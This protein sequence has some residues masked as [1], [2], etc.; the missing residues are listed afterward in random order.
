MV[1]VRKVRSTSFWMTQW[2]SASLKSRKTDGHERSRA[3][4]SSS[5]F[6][7]SCIFSRVDKHFPGLVVVKHSLHILHQRSRNSEYARS[8]RMLARLPLCISFCYCSAAADFWSKCCRT[9]FACRLRSVKL[10]VYVGAC[11]LACVRARIRACL[12]LRSACQY[13]ICA[14][15]STTCCSLASCHC[16]RAW[17]RW[18]KSLLWRL[19]I[20][21]VT[22][23]V[24]DGNHPICWSVQVKNYCR[25]EALYTTRVLTKCNL[26]FNNKSPKSEAVE[27]LKNMLLGNRFHV[28]FT[29]L[30]S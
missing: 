27:S 17:A 29:H 25:C 12:C 22:I 18:I 19:D 7:P 4:L 24:E 11:V 16:S 2:R 1:G 13:G 8:P 20:V 30:H 3:F 14:I 28:F 23:E 21:Q 15:C 6:V 10:R 9:T 26:Y 5:N